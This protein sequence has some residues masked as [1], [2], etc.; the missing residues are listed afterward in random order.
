MFLSSAFRIYPSAEQKEMLEKLIDGF[1]DETNKVINYFVNHQC[2]KFIEYNRINDVVPWSSKNEVIKQAR[3]DFRKIKLGQ[4]KTSRF[5]YDYCKWSR[6][7]FRFIENQKLLIETSKREMMPLE[8]HYNDFIKDKINNSS[9]T[10]LKIRKRM[11]KWIATITYQTSKKTND[12]KNIMGVDL[13][14]KVP[15]VAAT[16]TGKIRFFG[17]GR[18]RRYL[19]TKYK[20]ELKKSLREQLP[21][22]NQRANTLSKRLKY[23]DH[24]I[25]K[26]IISF[27]ANEK[28]GLIKLENLN[29]LHKN[30]SNTIVSTWSYH[31]LMNYIIYKAKK[32]GIKTVLINPR[33]TS[34]RC[35]KCKKLNNPTKRN[36]EC[37]CGYKNHRDI[38]G[39]INV[40]NY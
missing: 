32:E 28:V 8:V 18:E 21:C 7:S 5:S 3:I 11:H 17:N 24:K 19:F 23:L 12:F 30:N 26:D 35:P 27:A 9:V 29:Q 6:M 15:A 16:S 39:A 38:V 20:S 10:S 1:N 40:L 34:K 36:Y 2:E 22:K 25:S 4:T 33:N 37:T 14:I 31:R 13:G